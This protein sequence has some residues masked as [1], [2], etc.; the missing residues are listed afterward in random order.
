MAL[1]KIPD[2]RLFWSKDP[3]VTKQWGNHKPFEVV[4][5]YPPIYK[6]I[7]FIAPKDL[8]QKDEKESELS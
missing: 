8:F 3:R 6:D 7:S 4:S 5:D 1:K 2:I